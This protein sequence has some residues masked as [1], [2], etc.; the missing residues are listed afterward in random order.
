MEPPATLPPP[1]TVRTSLYLSQDMLD[2]LQRLAREVNTSVAELVRA[3]IATDRLLREAVDQGGRV[4]I[5]E[6]RGL[7]EVVIPR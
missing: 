7:R 1:P 4:V 5:V 3:A 6:K 2:A